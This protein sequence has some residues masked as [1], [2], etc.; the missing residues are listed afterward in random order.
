MAVNDVTT[1]IPEEYSSEVVQRVTQRSVI[2]AMARSWPM[3]N[4]LRHVPRSAGM[5]VAGVA[6]GGTYAEDSSTNDEV[7]LT[8]RKMGQALRLNE[9]DLADSSL[10]DVINTKKMDWATSFAKFYDQAALGCTAAENGTTV[11]FTS[12]Y[13]S[14][15]TTQSGL[16]YTADDNYV[17]SASGSAVSYDNLSDTLSRVE[18]GD[19]WD[20]GSALVIA[21]P[22]FKAKMRGIKDTNGTPIFVQGTAG[23]PDT[24]FGHQ[25]F[26]T[27]GAKTHA[28]N[29]SNPTG[30]P[31]LIVCNREFLYKGVRSGPESAIAGAD[32]GPA[33][34]TDQALI[35]I[36]AR[37]AF[38]VAHPR[39]FAVL[40]DA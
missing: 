38:A 5:D 28:T 21:H 12:V 18:T 16:S 23:T 3:A 32:S 40:E 26:Y 17:V 25:I 13:K 37:R 11:L 6:A 22:S 39:A 27:L 24:L 7:L 29:T 14:I 36:R 2:E 35:K 9:E 34:L 8:A 1:W 33:F 4:N 30:N 15:R 19:Y 20:E 10:V 31:L